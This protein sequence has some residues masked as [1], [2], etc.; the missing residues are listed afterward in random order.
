VTLQTFDVAIAG[1][2]VIG[3]TI[4]LEL[5]EAGLRVG[6][7][8]AREPG[9]EASWASAGMLA[10]SPENEEMAPFV[11][12]SVASAKLY[13][14]L[15]QKVEELSGM[16]V[17]F[18]Q[19]GALEVAFDEKSASE[20][21]AGV[22]LQKKMGLKAEEVNGERAR[23]IEPVLS[24]DVHTAMW[25]ED[26]ASLDPRTFTEAALKAASR[27]GVKLFAGNGAKAL[28]KD[29]ARCKGLMLDKGQVEAKWT[30]VAAGCFSARIEGVAP[31][32]PVFPAK[33]QMI[34]LRC[35]T[36]ELE[37]TLWAGHTYLVPRSDGRI[38][39]GATIERTGFDRYVTAGGMKAILNEAIRIAPTLEK[40][41]IVDSWAGLRPD[42]PDHLPIVGPTDVEGLLIATGHFRSGI[43]LA[44]ITARLIREWVSTQRVSL[45]W[46][47]VSPMRFGEKRSGAGN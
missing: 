1:G 39:A 8:D 37:H 20:L 42:T 7:F 21:R 16:T 18:R 47:R 36:G 35:D 33:G 3:A 11:P 27:K 10:P 4:A 40:A 22:T 15:V 41:R 28:W 43:L 12:M 24:G 32:A 34:A 13:P 31:Y 9:R 46:A 29:G 25:R 17:G 5:A 26:E 38:I 19:D 30:V 2:G 6:L 23:K 45:D 44:P 14:E